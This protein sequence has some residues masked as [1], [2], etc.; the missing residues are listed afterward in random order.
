MLIVN[1]TDFKM[2]QVQLYQLHQ[3]NEYN[4]TYIEQEP[5]FIFLITIKLFTKAKLRLIRSS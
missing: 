4:S 1:T 5:L 2:E 3:L